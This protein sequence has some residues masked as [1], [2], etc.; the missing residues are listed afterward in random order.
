MLPPDI[1]LQAPPNLT[2]DFSSLLDAGIDDWGGVSPVTADHVNPERAWPALDR[3]RQVTEQHGHVLAPRLAVHPEWAQAEIR[4]RRALRHSVMDRSDAEG[5]GPGLEWCSGGEAA[6]AAP[7]DRASWPA[8]RSRPPGRAARLGA[9]AERS[10]RVGGAVGEVLTG[11]LAGQEV[12]EDE[13]VTLFRRPGPRSGRGRR[14]RRRAAAGGGR[15]RG[16]LRGQP[17][18]QLHQHLHVQVQVLRLLQRAPCP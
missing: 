17:E 7:A 4:G 16:H 3:L 2:E 14:G 13:I 8:D 5:L 6:P 15:R 11:V 18:H 9:G 12:G 1:H 10:R